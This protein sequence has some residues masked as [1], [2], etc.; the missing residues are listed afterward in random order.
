MRSPNEVGR[1]ADRPRL[2]TRLLDRRRLAHQ[3]ASRRPAAATDTAATRRRILIPPAVLP[4]PCRHRPG[5]AMPA[6]AEITLLARPRRPIPRHVHN[7]SRRTTALNPTE[8]LS[9]GPKRPN[10]A[11]YQPRRAIDPCVWNTYTRSLGGG[12]GGL[13]PGQIVVMKDVLHLPVARQPE[14]Y[15]LVGLIQDAGLHHVGSC[16]KE[17]FVPC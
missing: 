8:T 15:S 6:P 14:G 17:A 11:P 12:I 2:H 13:F 16:F 9:Q 1:S 5:G 7:P 10:R 4:H 3:T